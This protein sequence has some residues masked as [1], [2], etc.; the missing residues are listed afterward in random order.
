M[1]GKLHFNQKPLKIGKLI[2]EIEIEVTY[3]S[4]EKIQNPMIA[5]SMDDNLTENEIL[6]A[7]IK[8]FLPALEQFCNLL[9]LEE[10]EIVLQLLKEDRSVQNNLREAYLN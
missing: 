6:R 8:D 1:K 9:A 3:Q 2:Y 4:S 10:E 7:A 5:F